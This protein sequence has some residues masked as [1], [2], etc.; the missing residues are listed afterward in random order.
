MTRILV[1]GITSPLGLAVGRRLQAEGHR[2]VG[3]LRSS[4]TTANNLPANELVVLD[5]EKRSSF[6]NI[7]GGFEAIVHVAAESEG[8]AEELM[9][10]T[11]LGTLHLIERAQHLGV[12]RIIHISSM[13]VYGDITDE[14]VNENTQIR[15]SIPY[16][17]AK[18]AAEC[19]LAN[20]SRELEAMSIRSPAI[21]GARTHRHFLAKMLNRMARSE[22]IILSSNPDHLFNNL[23]HE[24]VL[25]EFIST[26]IQKQS[27]GLF[28]AFPI[29]STD[30]MPLREIVARLAYK[31]KFKGEVKWV[32]TKSS[33]FRIDSSGAIDLGYKPITTNETLDRWMSDADL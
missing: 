10:I 6:S 32:E 22:A 30:P 7:S 20:K 2:V 29:G 24:D 16:G 26:L 9:T 18:W 17:A 12:K 8:S 15:Q 21:A 28:R 25:A 5:L 11:G 33:P 31:T 23:V 1:T 27:L 13:A 4:R 3:T 14:V 19:Y